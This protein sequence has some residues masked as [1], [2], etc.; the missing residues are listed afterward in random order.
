MNVINY[1]IFNKKITYVLSV[2][3]LVLG[4][5]SYFNL[6]R[7][8]DP[9]F[10]IKEAVIT[11]YYPG[12]TSLQVEKEVTDKIEKSIQ[13]LKQLKEVRSISRAGVSMVFAEIQENF[14]KQTL[15]QVWDELRRKMQQVQSDLPEGVTEP[16]VNDDFGDV[17]GTLFAITG[18]GYSLRELKSY[19]EDLQRELLLA[20]DVGRIELWGEQTDTVNIEIDRNKIAKFGIALQSVIDAI[21]DRHAVVNTGT[22]KV[23]AKETHLRL[24]GDFSDFSD[25]EN[26]LIFD[27]QEKR[28]VRLKD[29]ATISRGYTDPA[30]EILLWNGEPALALGISTISGGDVIAMGAD[31]HQR[32]DHLFAR[33]PIG[34]SVHFIADQAKTVK[35]ASDGFVLN[36]VAAVLI[37]IFVLILFMGWRE[38]LIIGVVLFITIMATFIGMY[39]MDITLQRISLGALI[40]SL[41][42]L[43][44]NA[45]VVTEGIALKFKSGAERER[46]ALQTVKESQWPLLGATIIAIL[47][48]AAITLS[49]DMTGEWLKSLF[50]V[51]CLSLSLSWVF[52]VTLTPFLCLHFMAEKKCDVAAKPQGQIMTLYCGI[53]V[54]CIKYRRTTLFA[55]FIV[56]M[57]SMWGFS[58]VKQ[59]FMPDMN[60]PQMTLDLWM[61]EGT[62]IEETKKEL[63]QVEEYVRQLEGVSGVATFVGSGP[64]RFLL[65][66]EPQMPNSAYGQ[67]IINLDDYQRI[68]DLKRHLIAYLDQH[69]SNAISSVDAFKLGPGGGSVVA[70]ISGS[71]PKILAAIAEQVKQVMRDHPNTRSIRTDWGEPV[72]TKLV[73]W[74]ENQSEELGVSRSDIAQSLAM[75]FSGS[76]IGYFREGKRLLPMVLRPV[77][78]Q[79][80]NLDDL[81]NMIIWGAASERWLPFEQVTQG[82]G[83]SWEYPVI[84][85]LNRNRV[86]RISTKQREGTTDALFRDL[87]PLIKALSIPKG[88]VLEWGGE[89]E[90]QVE[91]NSKLMSNVPIAFALMFLISV[92]L[93]DSLRHPMIIFLGLPLAVIGVANGMLIADKP[94]GFMA[95]LGFLSLFGMLI[96]NEIVLLDQINIELEEGKSAYC[97]VLDAAI[98]R[99]R[100][101]CMS[102]VTTVLGMIPLLWDAFFAPMAVTIMGGLTFATIL[103]LI[104]IPV[105]Y[106]I[107]FTVNPSSSNIKKDTAL[108]I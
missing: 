34:I 16:F 100:P 76:I 31:I 9:E 62:H 91:A 20:T 36:L 86:L 59:D 41:G 66:Y 101:V 2:L 53:L 8:E 22:V 103:T 58:H 42:M 108:L 35:E 39:E 60:R 72:K 96:K 75:N 6:G 67:L 12:A 11:T 92:M 79:R 23:G 54:G 80:K 5:V 45:I 107:F 14:D 104:V 93:F 71:D 94:F 40:I 24:N 74:S 55:V 15:P 61:P 46:A 17:Y 56:L 10:S 97:S 44:D 43:V 33:T 88:Y 63:K 18:E 81:K 19:A 38:G 90:E 99:V 49:E 52:A 73:Q 83:I 28:Y 87:Q 98:N 77:V 32:L 69:H 68:P 106:C 84:H 102:A 51:I 13:Q 65:T 21:N 78:E 50:Q 57:A 27:K 85:R 30:S 4:M 25:L 3:V 48:F 82:S 37:V 64:P 89:H 47:A 1:L 29:I 26:Q 70:R 95:M 105:L 7:L